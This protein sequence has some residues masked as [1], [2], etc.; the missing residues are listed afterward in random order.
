MVAVVA[1]IGIACGGNGNPTIAVSP[2]ARSSPVATPTLACPNEAAVASD[3]GLRIGGTLSGD[4]SA[5]GTDDDVSLHLD[6]S[7]PIGCQAFVVVETE[8]GVRAAPVW[9]LGA[10]GGLPAP[11]LSLLVRIGGGSGA[12]VLVNEASGASTQFVGAFTMTGGSLQR[13]QLGE[14]TGAGPPGAGME[15]LFAFGGSVGHLEAVDCTSDGIVVSVAVPAEGRSA[16]AR[17]TYEVTR[18]L[19]ELSDA[20]LVL[21]SRERARLPIDDLNAEFPEFAR[22]PFLSCPPAGNSD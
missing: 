9:L 11:S 1:S 14:A 19:F 6:E 12:E 20:T 5:D 10:D 3:A 13:L 22:S 16:F 15:G 4:V 8:A 18:R 2:S 7:A 21:A 17:G